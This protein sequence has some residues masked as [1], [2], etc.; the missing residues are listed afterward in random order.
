MQLP[1]VE[2]S[3]SLQPPAASISSTLVNKVIPVAPVNP[4]GMAFANSSGA[5]NAAVAGADSSGV[6]NH[7][8]AAAQLGSVPANAND[9]PPVYTS[10]PDP[11]TSTAA[12]RHGPHDWTVQHPSPTEAAQ[13][14][15]KPVSQVVTDSMRSMYTESANTVQMEQI[16]NQLTPPVTAADAAQN[17][18]QAATQALVYQPGIVGRTQAL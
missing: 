5:S 18:G 12:S 11:L 7:I 15:A 9:G 17:M 3:A 16:K 10:V 8:S 4:P 6:V 2:R 14:A 13:P 1:P